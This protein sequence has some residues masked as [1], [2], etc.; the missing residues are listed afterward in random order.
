MLPTASISLS[1]GQHTIIDASDLTLAS[2]FRWYASPAYLNGKHTY[3]AVTKV[4]T[5]DGTKTTL[6][7]HRLITGAP[8]GKV[9]DHIN[10]D[11]LDNRRANLR[12]VTQV[13]NERNSARCEVTQCPASHPYDDA[14]THMNKKGHRI[15]RACARDRMATKLAAETPEQRAER[16]AR[17]RI[18]YEQNRQR[19]ITRNVA[20][21]Q[22]R[23]A[24]PD[25]DLRQQKEE[26]GLWQR[27]SLP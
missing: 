7:L 21:K 16:A 24:D 5:A 25:R 20:Y 14:N 9:V 4:R 11:P 3:Y 8:K 19:I 22:R 17:D 13:E 15:C 12:I 1:R 6:Y 23:R 18:Y 27:T 26:L 10:R 2:Q